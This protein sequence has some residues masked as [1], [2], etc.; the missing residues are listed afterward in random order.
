LRRAPAADIP[1]AKRVLNALIGVDPVWRALESAPFDDEEA[2][3]EEE[4]GLAEAEEEFRRG[5]ITT[6]EEILREFRIR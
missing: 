6:H 3:S 4:T 1:V 2:S 5:E